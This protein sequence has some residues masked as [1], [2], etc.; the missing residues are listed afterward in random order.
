MLV[1]VFVVG[2]PSNDI[3]NAENFGVLDFCLTYVVYALYKL[4]SLLIF[5]IFQ[6]DIN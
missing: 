5:G 6:V 4:T 1:H 3:C 2:L